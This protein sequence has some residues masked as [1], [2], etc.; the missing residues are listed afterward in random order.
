MAFAILVPTNLIIRLPFWSETGC[1]IRLL[2]MSI[3]LLIYEKLLKGIFPLLF[4][5]HNWTCLRLLEIGVLLHVFCNSRVQSL[6]FRWKEW[7]DL[8]IRQCIAV[9]KVK[10]VFC[11]AQN[12]GIAFLQS[13]DFALK[14][15]RGR[16]W[17][18]I[19]FDTFQRKARSF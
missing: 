12:F 11:V 17:L 9:K 7:G 3:G 5:I 16:L 13:H 4:L 1:N 6:S 2:K 8:F 18:G 14:A 19:V 15:K 10:F